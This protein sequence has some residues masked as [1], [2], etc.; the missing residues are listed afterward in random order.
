M[1]VILAEA[2]ITAQPSKGSLHNPALRNH[3]KALCTRRTE[4]NLQFEVKGR[5]DPSFEV[6]PIVAAISQDLLQT[7]PERSWQGLQQPFCPFP[8]PDIGGMGNNFQ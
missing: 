4:V 8:F 7:L 6:I 5:V 3:D 1:F 2:T